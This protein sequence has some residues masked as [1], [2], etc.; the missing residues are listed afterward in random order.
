MRCG[1]R[2]L[3]AAFGRTCRSAC[4]SAARHEY[5]HDR[6][7]LFEVDYFRSGGTSA[8]GD[9]ATG[10]A[11]GESENGSVLQD[12]GARG[13]GFE[14]KPSPF[15]PVR[16]YLLG[17]AEGNLAAFPCGP[18]LT[19]LHLALAANGSV[20]AA[21]WDRASRLG[22]MTCLADSP[23][24]NTLL[25]AVVQAFHWKQQLDTGKFEL[26]GDLAEAEKLDRSFVWHVEIGATRAS[27]SRYS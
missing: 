11:R 13:K 14:S 15:W 26:I 9:R 16:S 10:A 27:E 22:T 12:C 6:A 4:G 5:G 8:T 2:A 1:I 23:F 3:C 24:C 20:S 21:K 25:R 7:P 17:M 18:H 19:R